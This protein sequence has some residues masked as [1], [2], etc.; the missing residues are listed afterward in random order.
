MVDKRLA[1]AA[2]AGSFLE[3]GGTLEAAGVRRTFLI[4]V[5]LIENE[6]QL[7]TRAAH[8]V[9]TVGAGRTVVSD[10]T[11]GTVV[12]AADVVEQITVAVHA[13][14]WVDNTAKSVGHALA[15]LCVWSR[16]EWSGHRIPSRSL[17]RA[18]GWGVARAVTVH[19]DTG[20]MHFGEL[21]LQIGEIL[22]RLDVIAID[23]NKT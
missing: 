12:M 15:E 19:L 20:W 9:C 1:S 11:A 14:A 22:A 21:V 13:F 5:V 18:S 2:G 7:L 3:F 16:W 10:A 4:F 23:R 17:L 6:A 8:A